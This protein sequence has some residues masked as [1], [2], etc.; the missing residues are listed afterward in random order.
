MAT[1]GVREVSPA[2]CAP[3]RAAMP[4]NEESRHI[5]KLRVTRLSARAAKQAFWLRDGL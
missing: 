4:Q 3:I 2:Y 1:R 5:A